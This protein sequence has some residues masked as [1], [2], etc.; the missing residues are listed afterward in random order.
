[1]CACIGALAVVHLPDIS[2]L[3]GA[4]I[5]TYGLITNGASIEAIVP[6]SPAARA[7]L[8]AGDRIDLALNSPLT[9]EA[10]TLEDLAPHPGSTL[11]LRLAVP[12]MRTVVLRAQSEPGS[13]GALIALRESLAFAPI[14]LGAALLLVRPGRL[15]WLL[16]LLTLD[17]HAAPSTVAYFRVFTA[18]FEQ[19]VL[20]LVQ[21]ITA[22]VATTAEV[23]FAFSLAG[24]AIRGW[25]IIPVVGA[26][27]VAI[28]QSLATTLN[29]WAPELTP[30]VTAPWLMI[31]EQVLL[32]IFVM[33]GI[34]DAYVNARGQ[35]RGKMLWLAAGLLLATV[36]NTVDA[37]WTND[38]YAI[39]TAFHVAP[40]A[41]VTL[42]AYVLLRTRVVDIR[43]AISRSLAY[44][45]ITAALVVAFA[46][47]D[48]VMVHVV[49]EG[50][51]A[52]P[53]DIVIAIVLGFSIHNIQGRVDTLVDRV[54]F[55]ARYLA[56]E[57]LARAAKAVLHVRSEHAV[58]EYAVDLPVRLLDLTG[59]ALYRRRAD[60]FVLTRERAWTHL[61][62]RCEAEDPL[63]VYLTSDLEP[64]AVADV[65]VHTAWPKDVD[66]AVPFVLRRELH[67]F[68]VYG[69]HRD[70]TQIDA[71]EQ[72]S[73]VELVRSA[74]LVYER[75][76]M[77]EMERELT[78]LRGLVALHGQT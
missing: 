56:A 1:M 31:L 68:V 64:I 36:L 72:R 27:C 4:P 48:L 57:G 14:L 52:L 12:R 23:T 43:F 40:L 69:A 29:V 22:V 66:L 73:L 49:N 35:V 13:D 51:L 67:G 46:M 59:A 28:P 7:G 16:F 45:A 24:H 55:R 9:R 39:H 5:A 62:R 74:D 41:F 34:A 78:R 19:F 76:A 54:L 75:I 42:C 77:A 25:R 61:P 71:T 65:A 8:R 63:C 2:R 58:A 6:G 26:A 18:P 38:S 32:F 21:I 11:V 60:G 70:G 3:L 15:T 44:G 33:A 20:D 30:V 10:L 53:F 37:V 17:A 50:R 47:V